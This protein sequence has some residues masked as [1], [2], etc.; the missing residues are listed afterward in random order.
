ME[1]VLDI[2]C[3]GVFCFFISLSLLRRL[4]LAF[5]IG[6]GERFLRCKEVGKGAFWSLR[7][8]LSFVVGCISSRVFIF[9]YLRKEDL[10]EKRLM[11]YSFGK[12]DRIFRRSR[13]G[14]VIGFG[15]IA[16]V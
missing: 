15:G 10:G 6:R 3:F 7:K 5:F 13:S 2:F 11:V 9:N 14:K 12:E 16:W 8:W 4:Y 1:M